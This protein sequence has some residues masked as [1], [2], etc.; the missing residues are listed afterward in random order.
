MKLVFS[1]DGKK[2]FEDCLIQSGSFFILKSFVFTKV[3]SQQIDQNGIIRTNQIRPSK[4]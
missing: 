4:K 2:Y 3:N 1:Y